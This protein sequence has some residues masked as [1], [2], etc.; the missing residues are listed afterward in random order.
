VHFQ[1][2]QE[3]S[4]DKGIMRENP[5]RRSSLFSKNDVDLIHF[6]QRRD[7]P[8]SLKAFFTKTAMECFQKYNIHRQRH[9]L[10]D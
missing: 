4:G 5:F 10:P 9:I 8:D 1:D 2:V 6:V 3:F 7:I